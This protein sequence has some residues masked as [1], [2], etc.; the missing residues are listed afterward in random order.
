MPATIEAPAAPA[1]A[2]V[3]PAAPASPAADRPA[4]SA[5]DYVKASP[6]P[7]TP[8]KKGSGMDRMYK[9]LEKVGV[10]EP[11]ATPAAEKPGETKPAEAA[12][13]RPGSE[14]ETPAGET[15][16]A[17]A[18][19][20]DDK[21]KTGK[22]SPWK[23]VDQFKAR[24]AT[25][26]KELA[27]VKA[28]ITP[29]SDRRLLSER[30]TKAEQRATELE[31]QMRLIRYESSQEFQEK[32][33]EPCKK[34]WAYCLKEMEGVPVIDETTGQERPMTAK[35]M[36][37]LTQL[38]I[39]DARK[40]A[41]EKFGPF[42]ND[43]LAQRKELKK[44][45]E[46]RADAIHKAKE[47]GALREQQQKEQTDRQAGE[48][49]KFIKTTWDR[50]VAEA[51]ADPKAGVFLKPREG[52][53]EWNTRLENGYKLVDEAFTGSVADPKLSPEQRAAMIRKHAAVRNRAAGWGA[54]RYENGTIKAK[55]EAAEKEL[56]K[57]KSSTPPAGGSAATA[58]T[59]ELKGMDRIAAELAKRAH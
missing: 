38:D 7:V 17:A 44:L 33:E 20:T 48:Q 40:L 13:E 39:A 18:A 9:D 15:P 49:A 24:A 2:P 51:L 57:Y 21:G 43:A 52:D 1:A 5:T 28:A 23:L 25:L 22:V 29:E 50:V 59:S 54:L 41:E 8:P 10:K 37:D 16:A 27:D 34:G 36:L 31:N 35:D 46:T 30:A 42:A 55:L 19:A 11:P 6:T 3:A 56:A 26:E 47:D 4:I 12:T 32:Y 58:Q 45:L 53:T 14:T